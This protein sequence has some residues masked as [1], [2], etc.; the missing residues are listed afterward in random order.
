MATSVMRTLRLRLANPRLALLLIVLLSLLLN[1]PG[2]WWGL[3]PGSP[4]DWGSDTNAPNQVFGAARRLFSG[5]WHGRY[6]PFHDQLLTLHYRRALALHVAGLLDVL[7]PGVYMVLF[8]L[9]RLPSLGMAAVVVILGYRVARDLELGAR[10]AILA[11]A[12]AS[13]NP[14]FVYYAKT[15]N[16]D[17]PYTMWLHALRLASSEVLLCA[18]LSNLDR[19]WQQ[20]D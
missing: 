5:G 19:I 7:S 1:L 4:E 3:L 9:G 10:A 2:S 12:I 8:S 16:L 11:A 18:E 15:T 13:L 6:P 14:L 17:I 20:H